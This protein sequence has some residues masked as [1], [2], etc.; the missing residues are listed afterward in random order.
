M[1]LAKTTSTSF[2]T[3][4][5][6]N[7]EIDVNAIH[8]KQVEMVFRQ[9]PWMLLADV[10]TGSFLF[11][12]IIT[13]SPSSIA[14]L[15]YGGLLIGNAGRAIIA[16]YY[17]RHSIQPDDVSAKWRF[18]LIGTLVAGIYWGCSWFLLP[19]DASLIQKGLIVLWLCGLLSGAA[20]TLSVIKKLYFAFAIPYS[21][22]LIGCLL[23]VGGDTELLLVSALAMYLFFLTP[24]VLRVSNDL[25]QG[26]KLQLRCESLYEQL[27]AEHVEL[28]EKGAHL[29]AQH[30]R[31]TNLK[32]E[33][34]LLLRDLENERKRHQFLLNATTGCMY[35][36]NKTGTIGFANSSALNLLKFGEHELIG[37]KSI[38]LISE[39]DFDTSSVIARCIENGKPVANMKGVF[40]N[41]RGTNLSVKFSCMP[42]FEQAEVT[43]AVINFS[44]IEELKK[45]LKKEKG[46]LRLVN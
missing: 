41:K 24:I 16:D 5:M 18:L 6:S 36:I 33:N 7:F 19:A 28:Q 15:W 45:E 2:P 9:F 42:V 21:T 34:A 20:T 10:V 46:E 1:E 23:F 43:G 37:E 44:I 30:T 32:S 11:V 26:I 25:N 12:L 14:I 27:A 3:N 22:I 40:K 39:S 8:I 38:K 4:P 17:K 29:V 13:T 35:V 31:E